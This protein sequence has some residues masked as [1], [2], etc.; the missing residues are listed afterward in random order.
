[1]LTDLDELIGEI[2]ESL[3]QRP[4]LLVGGSLENGGDLFVALATLLT[5]RVGDLHHLPKGLL[6][7]NLHDVDDNLREGLG[8]FVVGMANAR[9][10]LRKYDEQLIRLQLVRDPSDERIGDIFKHSFNVVDL[11]HR[12][13][14]L[15]LTLGSVGRTNLVV[16]LLQIADVRRQFEPLLEDE[17]QR[18]IEELRAVF[19]T[20]NVILENLFDEAVFPGA[21]A[22][23]L[24]TLQ[25]LANAV[26]GEVVSLFPRGSELQFGNGLEETELRI[27]T[28]Q[29]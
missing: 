23:F 29:L 4:I 15:G 1:M 3:E 8:D 26:A 20:G 25:V 18:L 11:L 24:L 5:R 12:V 21:A 28:E 22:H 27:E 2:R 7:K 19:Q 14:R 9:D 10:E 13:A 16:F 17:R 6:R